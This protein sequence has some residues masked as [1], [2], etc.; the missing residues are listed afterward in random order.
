MPGCTN[1]GLTCCMCWYLYTSVFLW[2]GLTLCPFHRWENW[3]AGSHIASQLLNPEPATQ[4]A[5]SRA[6]DFRLSLVII[7]ASILPSCPWINWGVDGGPRGQPCFS[8]AGMEGSGLYSKPRRSSGAGPA[9]MCSDPAFRRRVF[10]Q[11]S[12]PPRAGGRGCDGWL[13][14]SEPGALWASRYPQSA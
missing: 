13:S 6:E 4:G 11:S 2:E 5:S 1:P 7:I 12:H 14:G 3:L 8:E 9:G 10:V